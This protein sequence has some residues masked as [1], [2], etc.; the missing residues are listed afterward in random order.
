MY[1]KQVNPMKYLQYFLNKK[2]YIQDELYWKVQYADF[3]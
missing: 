3:H 1:T 2:L